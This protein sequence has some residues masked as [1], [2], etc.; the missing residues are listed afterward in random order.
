MTK[1]ENWK[2]T[3]EQNLKKQY[4]YSKAMSA[5]GAELEAKKTYPNATVLS[6][7]RQIAQKKGNQAAREIR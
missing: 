1:S 2:V 4:F 6:V 3:V 7:E 5:K